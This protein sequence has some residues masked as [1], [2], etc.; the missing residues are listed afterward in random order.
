MLP[1]QPQTLNPQASFVVKASTG[2][3]FEDVDL[4]DKEWVEFDD[5]A[6]E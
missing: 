2:K 4:S 3:T 1:D 6:N 5:D